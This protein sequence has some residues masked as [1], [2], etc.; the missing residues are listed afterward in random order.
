MTP[1][2]LVLLFSALYHLSDLSTVPAATYECN[3]VVVDNGA[4]GARGQREEPAGAE[5]GAGGGRGEEQR[6]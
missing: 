3:S 6:G 4:R 1:V 5:G 2:V